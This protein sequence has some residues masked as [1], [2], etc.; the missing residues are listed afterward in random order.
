MPK[1]N[2]VGI[3]KRR[4]WA[5]G[6]AVRDM[7][8]TG[9][10]FDLL[11]DEEKKVLVRPEGTRFNHV[12]E[13]VVAFVSFDAAD[14]AVVIYGRAGFLNTVSPREAFGLPAKSK[15]HEKSSKKSSKKGTGKEGRA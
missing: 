13:E 10:G 4:I 11:V 7:S 12:S 9:L 5:S 15:D 2:I 6:Y 14:R 1:D 8:K 3:V